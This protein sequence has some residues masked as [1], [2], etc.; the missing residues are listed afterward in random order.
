MENVMIVNGEELSPEAAAAATGI[1]GAFFGASFAVFAIIALV[2]YVLEVIAYWKIF[3]KAGKPGW[4]SIIPIL[5]NFD[6]VDLSWNR[7]MAW[8]SIGISFAGCI[9]STVMQTQTEPS[10]FIMIIACILA[11][12]AIVF[13]FFINYKLAKAFGKGIGFFLGLTFLSPIFR[14]ILGFGNAEYQGPQA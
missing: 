12:A 13:G 2:F 6:E 10:N 5:N 3:K 14:L 8:A 7:T 9:V 11:G 4:H 1:F